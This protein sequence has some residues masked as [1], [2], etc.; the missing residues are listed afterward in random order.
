[1]VQLLLAESFFQRF[2]GL[3]TLRAYRHVNESKSTPRNHIRSRFVNS[4]MWVDFLILQ[5]PDHAR[6]GGI[7]LFHE[8]TLPL[9]HPDDSIGQ[10][11]ERELIENA[12]YPSTIPLTPLEFETLNDNPL[13]LRPCEAD[14]LMG[15]LTDKPIAPSAPGIL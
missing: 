3:H 14:N 5:V 8:N 13:L 10:T 15:N 1:M 2:L 12:V 4:K 7:D 11:P 9:S 6:E